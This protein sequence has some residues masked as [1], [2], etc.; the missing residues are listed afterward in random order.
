MNEMEELNSLNLREL[1][2]L[3]EKKL[4]AGEDVTEV[5]IFISDIIVNMKPADVLNKISALC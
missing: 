5:C 1:Y 2:E 4:K 3:Y